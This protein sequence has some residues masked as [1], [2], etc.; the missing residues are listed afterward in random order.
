VEATPEELSAAR[1][2]HEK[3]LGPYPDPAGDEFDLYFE[4]TSSV[5]WPKVWLEP[6]L[7]PKTRSLCVV[8]ALTAMGRPQVGKH[9]RGALAN[10]ASKAEIGQL[11]TQMAFYAGWP[12]AG[13]AIN[14]AREIFREVPD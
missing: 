1:A 8:A 3:V 2:F 6:Q 13:A 12:A 10:G 7:D 11:L 5:L 4:I 9:I 14:Q